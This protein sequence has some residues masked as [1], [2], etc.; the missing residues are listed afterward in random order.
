MQDVVVG[1]RVVF[2]LGL[3]F[4]EVQVARDEH[5]THVEGQFEIGPGQVAG[6]YDVGLRVGLVV[7]RVAVHVLNLRI[8]QTNHRTN[9]NAKRLSR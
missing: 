7:R 3:E 8:H 4:G 2:K 5:L 1:G 9:H 6:D